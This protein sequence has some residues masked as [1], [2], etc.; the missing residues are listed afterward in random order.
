MAQFPTG[1]WGVDF[2]WS[3]PDELYEQLDSEFHFDLDAAASDS[4][5]KCDRYFT[6]ED[7][8][9]KQEWKGTVWCNP[10]YGRGI[11]SWVQKASE[12]Y[13][14]VTVML[15]PVRTDTAWWNDYIKDRA[16]VRYIRGRIKFNGTKENAP[17]ASAI[18]IFRG[19]D[20]AIEVIDRYVECRHMSLVCFDDCTRCPHNY[21]PD[22]LTKSLELVIRYLKQE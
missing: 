6:I 7:D 21:D 12:R 18:V 1:K 5:H 22:E 14:G 8:G 3:T 20:E 15:L 17:F 13:D 4:N 19:I 16:E 9:L 10:P 2:E 11:G